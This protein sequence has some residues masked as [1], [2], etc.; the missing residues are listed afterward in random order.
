MRR[1]WVLAFC[2]LAVC[3]FARPRTLQAQQSSVD[4]SSYQFRIDLPDTG[5]AIHGWASVFFD[6]RRG[7]DDTL[8]L[9]LV[10]MSV[11]KVVGI[12]SL[13]AVPFSHD[14]HVL[15]I[16]TRALG[17]GSLGIMVEYHGTPSDGL[18]YSAANARGRRSFFGDNWPNRAR[19]W[20]PTMDHPS[21][22]A[23][24]MWSVHAPA[25]M[26]VVTNA[27]QC[28]SS[29]IASAQSPQAGRSAS[30]CAESAPIPTY[31]MVLAAT[32]MTKSVHRSAIS[33]SDIVPIE[34]WTYPEDSAFADS[35]PFKRATEIVEVMSRLIGPFRYGR[36]AHLQSST[37]Y[38][39]MENSSAIFYAE[40][41]YVRRTM[42]EGVVRHESAHQWFGDAVTEADW[43]HVWLSESFATYFDA[44]VAGQLDGDSAMKRVMLA[45]RQQYLAS[46]V[47]NTPIIDTTIVDPN[48]V[49]NANTYPK[50]AWVLQMLRHTVGDSAFFHGLRDYYTTYRDSSVLTDA[51]EGKIESASGANLGWFFHQWLWQPGYP[52]LQITADSSGMMAI[53]QAQPA[54]WGTFRI[55]RLPVGLTGAG[56]PARM[57]VD[58]AAA[59]DQR[60]PLTPG[61]HP[62]SIRIDPDQDWLISQ[63]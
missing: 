3:P 59:A 21:D 29:R 53:H 48:N 5:S 25:G 14:G 23:R 56:C 4:V 19:F 20:L 1:R 38:G 41:P 13:R 61:C 57:T 45:D 16:A 43:H 39:G 40:Q 10:G 12:R 54:A 58:L 28:E 60:V 2:L 22:K 51:L 26:Q 15:R 50:G 46:H 32:R 33:G 42:G 30:S 36:L 8:R 49:L 44:V 6:T 37:R 27:P 34:V 18:I 11:D 7:Y 62:E 63:N 35:V 9:D 17:R 31:T 47:I 55:D 24:V 52:Q